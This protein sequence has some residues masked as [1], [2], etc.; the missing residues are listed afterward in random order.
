MREQPRFAWEAS[1]RVR[2]RRGAGPL[3]AVVLTGC[4]LFL[5]LQALW[6]LTPADG[7]RSRP[8]VV[9]IPAHRGLVDVARI[10]DDAEVIRSPMG[11]ALL[12]ILHGNMRSLKAG[13]YQIPQQATTVAV[14]NML[15]GGQVLQHTIV[16]R[17]GDTLTELAGQLSAEGLAQSDDI[18]R[19]TRDTVF[20]RTL[21]IPA[22]SLEGYLFP[23]T[24]QFVKGMTPEEILARMVTRL[25]ER[26]SADILAAARSRNLSFHELLTLASIIEKEA[27]D[28]SEMPLISAVF[29]NRLRIEMPLQADPT[30]QYA[31]GKERRRLT[32][33]DLQVESPFNTYRRVGLPPGPIA[34]PGL[35][36]IRA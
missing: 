6:V 3:I 21:D 29:W 1:D 13:E 35:A 33:D 14:L 17:E 18:V 22:D 26:V 28:R 32:R 5:G 16:F 11:F 2:P 25:R 36:A 20:L 30:V 7:V 24:Y 34:S 4:L 9:E 27:V 15:A 10:L 8:R 23:D 12:T 31:V 19:L